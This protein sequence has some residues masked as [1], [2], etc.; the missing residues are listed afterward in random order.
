ME[1]KLILKELEE[2]YGWTGTKEF[3]EM[4][5]E[6]VNDVAKIVKHL[7]DNSNRLEKLVMPKIED[8]E[9][10]RNLIELFWQMLRTIESH[11]NPQENILDKIQV[12]DAYKLWNRINKQ[13]LKP[14]WQE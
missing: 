5:K 9:D 7:R 6:L 12:E 3:T 10:G 4:Q 11:T 8:L 2:N 14:R 1:Y 13:N